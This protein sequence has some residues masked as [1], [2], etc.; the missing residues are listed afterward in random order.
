[1]KLVHVKSVGW[2]V[3][4]TEV[5]SLATQ[6]IPHGSTVQASLHITTT[7]EGVYSMLFGQIFSSVLTTGSVPLVVAQRRTLMEVGLLEAT[8]IFAQGH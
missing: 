7:L 6:Q 8:D 4:E 3:P 5:L 1:M 2:T